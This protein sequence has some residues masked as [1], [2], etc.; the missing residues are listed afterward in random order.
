MVAA[1]T[2]DVAEHLL[3]QDESIERLNALLQ[4]IDRAVLLAYAF[5]KKLEDELLE[6]FVGHEAARTLRHR[7]SHWGTPVVDREPHETH[8]AIGDFLV[9][10][11]LD[12]PAQVDP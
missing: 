9:L 1:Y 2:R 7:A 3:D 12:D 10:P 11:E 8:A 4:V 5:P 6:F